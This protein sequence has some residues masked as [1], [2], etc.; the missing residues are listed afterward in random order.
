MPVQTS[1]GP[2]TPR[3]LVLLI[4]RQFSTVIC[5]QP[6]EPSLPMR[7]SPAWSLR[8]SPSWESGPPPP[9][10]LGGNPG[11]V[12]AVPRDGGGWT[13]RSPSERCVASTGEHPEFGKGLP[14]RQAVRSAL[15][16]MRT[17]GGPIRRRAFCVVSAAEAPS[18]A[19][20]R[21]RVICIGRDG[22]PACTRRVAGCA[23]FRTRPPSTPAPGMAHCGSVRIATLP[24]RRCPQSQRLPPPP[25]H[26]SRKCRARPVPRP[27]I[28]NR[29]R[30]RGKRVSP[31]SGRAAKRRSNRNPSCW[32]RFDASDQCRRGAFPLP[33]R[34]LPPCS[35]P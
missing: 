29:W 18:A 27:L 24:R 2:T 30:G 12:G 20:L 33:H 19:P 34:R 9:N 35:D 22:L 3:T 17:N 7:R 14:R 13:A 16:A 8:L 32:S 1:S 11:R 5:L 15:W 21:P 31:G 28:G 23:A 10:C 6:G 25:L 26:H 4:V